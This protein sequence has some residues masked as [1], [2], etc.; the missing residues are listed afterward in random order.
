MSVCKIALQ[1]I[2]KI[3]FI[4]TKGMTANQVYAK[5]KPN[6]MINGA[7]YDMATHKNIVNVEDENVKDGYLFSSQGIGINGLKYLLW[8]DYETAKKDN[9][10]RDFIG[11]APCLVKGGEVNIDWGNKRSSQVDGSKYRSCIGFN[12]THFFMVGSDHPNTLQG[13]AEYCINQGMKYAINLDGGGSCHLQQGTRKLKS[14]SRANA[15]WILVYLKKGNAKEEEKVESVKVKC[16]GKE[17]EGFIKDGVTYV[18]VRFVGE[19]LSANVAWDG[20][21]KT[22]TVTPKEG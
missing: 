10:I 18:P 21:N 6:F 17:Q 1:D 9:D 19:N 13:L 5:Y 12:A 16:N 22:V 20:T 3:D 8:T 7:L 4:N 11:G 14:S 15:S 2:E